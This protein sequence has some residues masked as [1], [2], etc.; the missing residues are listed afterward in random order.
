MAS[1]RR[2]NGRMR[3]KRRGRSRGHAS[4]KPQRKRFNRRYHIGVHKD[5]H[6]E[7]ALVG[8]GNHLGTLPMAAQANLRLWQY[9]TDT[10]L[11]ASTGSFESLRYRVDSLYDPNYVSGNAQPRGYDQWMALYQ[12]YRVKQVRV[13]VTFRVYPDPNLAGEKFWLRFAVRGTTTTPAQIVDDIL[14]RKRDLLRPV[15]IHADKPVVITQTL[16]INPF[17][18]VKA[19][20]SRYDSKSGFAGVSSHPTYESGA[21]PILSIGILSQPGAIFLPT[22]TYGIE[23]CLDFKSEFKR[24]QLL[25]AS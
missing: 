25:A 21:V 22:M 23:A 20:S 1:R 3:A 9:V 4:R 16:Y 15:V 2:R 17:K 13:K 24:P 7:Q 18:L 6:I 19:V 10:T 14:E 11:P 8:G 5:S 12:L